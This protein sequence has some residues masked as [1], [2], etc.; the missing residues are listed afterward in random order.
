MEPAADNTILV[1]GPLPI[2]DVELP[3]IDDDGVLRFSDRWVAVSVAQLP[4]VRLLVSRFGDIVDLAEVVAV[5]GDAGYM[6]TERSIH[7]LVSRLQDK[8]RDVGLQ[9][10]A[11]RRQGLIL[12]PTVR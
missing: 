7:S 5:Y 9:L 10:A 8:V 12:V 3:E 1:R 11:V 6:T 2:T 4:V